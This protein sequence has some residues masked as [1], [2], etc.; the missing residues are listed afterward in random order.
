M[1]TQ[2]YVVAHKKFTYPLPK[3]YDYILVGANGKENCYKYSDNTLD[4]ISDK[5]KYYCELTAGYWIWK[6]DNESDIVGLVH[7]RRHFTRNIFSKSIKNYLNEPQISR[8]LKKH[9]IICTKLYK[10]K[11][12]VRDHILINVSKHDLDLLEQS[13]KNVCPEYLDTFYNV[14]NGHKSYLLNMFISKKNLWD[15]YYSWL[16][17]IFNDMEP[18][19][20]MT[21]YTVQQQR[22]YGFLSERLLTVYIMY[23]KLNVKSYSTYIVGES[24]FRI[25]RQKILKILRIK[26]D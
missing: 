25:F 10:T 3:N 17:K 11:D 2:I 12:T 4:N 1:K 22:L 23:N 5:N 24:K 7:Y 14:L 15:D 8:D 18:N 16:F 9:D 13:I 20:D 26:K 6:N 19:V 21:G